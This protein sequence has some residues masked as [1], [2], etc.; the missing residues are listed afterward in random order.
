VTSTSAGYG[1]DEFAGTAWH[2]KSAFV[3]LFAVTTTLSV[4]AHRSAA[5]PPGWPETPPTIE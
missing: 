2:S 3:V 5:D 1:V 4:S